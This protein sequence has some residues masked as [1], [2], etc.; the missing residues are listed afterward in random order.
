MNFSDIKTHILEKLKNELSPQLYYHGLHHTLDVYY[1][2]LQL[3]R[4]E[5]IDQEDKSLVLTAALFH[6]VGFIEQYDNNEHIA[7]KMVEEMLPDFGYNSD[8]IESISKIIL[9]TQLEVSPQNT[10]E[11]IMCDADHDYFGRSDYHEIASSLQKELAAF[12]MPMDEREWIS[13]QIDFLETKHRFFTKTSMASKS[14]KKRQ[15]IDELRVQ[16]NT[17]DNS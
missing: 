6:D 8:Q 14:L 3:C 1:S 7:V 15:N 5:Q 11:D 10:L 4:D 13:R 16:L 9:S 2:A 12:G 17:L